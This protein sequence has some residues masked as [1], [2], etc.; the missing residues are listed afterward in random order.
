[1]EYGIINGYDNHL[2][3]VIDFEFNQ[4]TS[5]W[6][7]WFNGNEW[8]EVKPFTEWSL[9]YDTDATNLKLLIGHNFDISGEIDLIIYAI[10]SEVELEIYNGKF[11]V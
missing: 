5:F 1:M 2:I 3:D 7:K 9:H 4:E 8:I 10:V 11:I 6:F